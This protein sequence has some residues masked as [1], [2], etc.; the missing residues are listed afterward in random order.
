MPIDDTA[1]A[2]LYPSSSDAQPE[3]KPAP[4]ERIV[5]GSDA[6][7][8]NKL[9][10]ETAAKDQAAN[11]QASKPSVAKPERA[12]G[13]KP[14]TSAAQTDAQVEAA[15]EVLAEAVGLDPDD[16]MTGQFSTFAVKHGIDNEGAA[17]LATMHY[18]KQV[19][20]WEKINQ[21][22][23]E[24]AER[25][26]AGEIET[27]REFLNSIRLDDEMEQF[28]D[29]YGNSPVLIRLLAAAGRR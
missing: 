9:F 19:A 3:A 29:A 27:A 21:S 23:R 2:A 22:W 4:V 16:A 1:L 6:D 24:E 7:R 28:V 15:A 25:L 12:D 17:E 5:P 13:S 8:A 10:G 18:E 20:D 14:T 11:D 26:P